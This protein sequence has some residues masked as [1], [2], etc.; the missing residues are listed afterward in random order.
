[1]SFTQ[2]LIVPWARATGLYSAP[3]SLILKLALGEAPE[4]IPAAFDVRRGTQTAVER[5]GHGPV[6][7]ILRRFS[8]Q[9]RIARVHAAAQPFRFTQGFSRIATGVAHEGFDDIEQTTGLARTFRINTDRQCCIGDLIDALRQLEMVES[10]SPRYLCALPFTASGSP[11][12][13]FDLDQAW[14]T[15]D[16]IRAPEAMAYEPGDP[17]VI[18]AIVDTGITLAHPELR[19]RL[20]PGFD[21]VELG[22]RDVAAGIQLTGDESDA[23]ADPEDEVGHGTSCA[24]II[25]AL[26]QQ[27]P[28]GLAG[29]CSLL[30]MRVLGAAKTPGKELPIGIGA[31]SDIDAGVKRAI[32]LGAK[33]LNMSFGT[34][35]SALDANDPRPHEDIV[36]YG[37]ARGC[38]MIAASGN[39]GQEERFLPAALEGVIAVGSVN[40]EGKPSSFSTR[41]AHVALAAPGEHVISTGLGGYQMATGTSF[42]APFVTATAA[43]LVSRALRKSYPLEGTTVRRLLMASAPYWRDPHIRGHGAGLLDAEAALRLLDREINL[44]A[45]QRR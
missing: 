1:M 4:H 36:R 41:G 7:R 23:D 18:V 6:D 14:R 38:V 27:I 35:E 30:P 15:R 5:T 11:A 31:L 20:R 42:A 21:T 25:G 44:A 10:A 28:P 9:V 19:H 12:I 29:E 8:E 24:G 2:Q 32:D 34:P 37:L 43:L 45:D 16:L 39:N 33:V 26:G 3:G 40:A 13:A 22:T 17:T